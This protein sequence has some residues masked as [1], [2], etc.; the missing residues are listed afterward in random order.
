MWTSPWRKRIKACYLWLKSKAKIRSAQV[1]ITQGVG[2]RVIRGE[3]VGYAY[4]DDL[5][6]AALL[7]AAET[8][9]F[10]AGKSSAFVSPIRIQKANF[11]SHYRIGLDPG[12]VA[13]S[14]KIEMMA[15]A[16]ETAKSYD[17][18]ITSVDVGFRDAETFFAILS[19]DGHY[20]RDN[21]VLFRMTVSAIVQ[22]GAGEAPVGEHPVV[23]GNGWGGVLLHEAVGHGLEA[24]FNRK[25]TSLFTGKVGKKVASDL[26][27][28]VDDGTL[29]NKRGTINVDDE[30]TKA[31]RTVLIELGAGGLWIEKGEILFP[32]SEITVAA[33]MRDLLAGIEAIA[34]DLEFR[35]GISSPSF[36][37][38]EMSISGT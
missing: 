28:I 24:D 3:K 19:S 35:G 30:G 9:S 15:R 36:L 34:D 18:R 32:V 25:K 5:D 2:I 7:L 10:I 20:A 11:P 16:N 38:R 12:S 14:R 8:A 13:V 26:V 21:N 6:L 37:V 31:Q 29:L 17:P 27:T 4:S 1:V 22:L 33:D 23:M